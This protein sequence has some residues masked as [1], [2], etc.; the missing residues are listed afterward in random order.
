MERLLKGMV[1][2]L[3]SL[4]VLVGV[5]WLF[6]RQNQVPSVKETA[7]ASA[8]PAVAAPGE[9]ELEGCR[10][11][12]VLTLR[13]HSGV[14]A[15]MTIQDADGQDIPTAPASEQEGGFTTACDRL[16]NDDASGDASPQFLKI[17]RAGTFVL[18]ITG[19]GKGLFDLQAK[20]LP[21]VVH[22]VAPL[23]LCNYTLD[24]ERGY[25]WVLKYQKGPRPA[26]FLLGSKG[27][28]N[29]KP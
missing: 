16:E 9:G 23:L 18:H 24:N 4:G 20:P 5:T 21:E 12:V 28:P 17:C 22:P 15:L 8:I 29:T 10:E 1:A 14:S 6:V 13:S 11:A 2:G 27:D 3:V 19:S 7:I 25:E 26:V